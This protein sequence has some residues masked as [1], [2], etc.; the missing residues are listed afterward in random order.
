M[1]LSI[2]LHL[3]L[4]QQCITK[5]NFQNRRR[6]NVNM[7]GNW[8]DFNCAR[9]D[10][11]TVD[12][13]LVSVFDLFGMTQLVRGPTR[14]VNLLDVIACGKDDHES[15][16]NVRLDDAGCLS[17]HLMVLAS[18]SFGWRRINPVSFSYRLIKSVDASLFETNLRA[19]PL[20]SN[21]ARTANGFADQRADVITGE[22]DKSSPLKTVTR[23]SSGK[24]INRFP[25]N[26]AVVA[27]QERRRLERH[28]KKTGKECDRLAY[29]QS[30]RSANE[31]I[32]KARRTYF[33]DRIANLSVDPVGGS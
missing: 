23:L 13:G 6:S 7:R 10:S 9:T 30:C 21:P 24:P 19:S 14:G 12:D 25:N 11:N 18:L 33:I 16:K 26:E 22:L 15:V 8:T 20:F 32:N 27:K 4:M 5:L 28:W 17:D 3:W 1:T 29:R 2:V 31:L